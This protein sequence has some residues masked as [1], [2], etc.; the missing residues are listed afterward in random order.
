MKI[1][2]CTLTLALLAAAPAAA[3]EPS[4]V[5]E[6]TVQSARV[7]KMEAAARIIVL[8]GEQKEKFDALYAEFQH[9]LDAAN[10][11]YASLAYRLLERSAVPPV[12]ETKRII[13]ELRD[14]E[15]KK[16]DLREQYFEQFGKFL[17][18]LQFIHLLQL[19]NKAD[20]ILKHEAVTQIPF[21]E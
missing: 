15:V 5:L 19:E 17:E 8:E 21:L 16:L 3:A 11:Q 2:V 1:V 7:R 4:A 10:E 18:P 13:R 9:A 20:A 12:D 6:S 14:L